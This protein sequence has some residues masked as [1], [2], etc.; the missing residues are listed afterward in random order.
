MGFKKLYGIEIQ[1]DAVEKAKLS[2]KNINIIQGSAFDIPFKEEYFDLIFTSGV[3]I[4]ISPYDLFL[5]LKEIVKCTKR[6]IW[7]FE[8]YSDEP[9]EIIYRGNVGFLWKRNFA[10]FYLQNFKKFKLIK[11]KKYKYVDNENIDQMFLIEKF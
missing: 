9:K 1:Y 7:G 6:Y 4:H 5:A 8:Y 11:E 10:N 3:L 2:T